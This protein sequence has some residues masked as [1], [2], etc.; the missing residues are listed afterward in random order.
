MLTP[1]AAI[2]TPAITAPTEPELVTTPVTKSAAPFA[3]PAPAI[4]LPVIV[5]PV[6]RPKVL[7]PQ[8][9]Q[10]LPPAS[11]PVATVTVVVAAAKV[12][13]ANALVPQ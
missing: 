7:P 5:A 11:P 6:L 8:D 2:S 12:P 10:R 4:T 13:Y 9:L 1:T 3:P